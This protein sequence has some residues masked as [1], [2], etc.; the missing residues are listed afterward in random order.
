[1]QKNVSPVNSSYKLLL[2]TFRTF[3]L[4]QLKI[5]ANAQKWEDIVFIAQ[6]TK[7][8]LT[9]TNSEIFSSLNVAIPFTNGTSKKHF[10]TIH[11]CKG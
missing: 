8:K 11:R 7:I 1:M 2:K 6:V 10:E 3:V 9:F 5:K 4:H